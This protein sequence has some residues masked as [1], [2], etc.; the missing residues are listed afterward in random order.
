MILALIATSVL[1]ISF[2]A[3]LLVLFGVALMVAE[4]FLPSFGVLGI[5]GFAA[6]VIGSVLLVDPHNEFGLRLSWTTIAPGVA[7]VALAA[8]TI[9]HL[10]LKA[11]R[12]RVNSG[13]ESLVGSMAVV[14]KDFGDGVG[15]VRISGED[16]AAQLQNPTGDQPRAGQEVTVKHVKGLVL[17]V[18]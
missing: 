5:G 9:G 14:L 15:R 10:I 13:V 3:L 11:K 1:P 12:S 6:F 2:G 4:M 17:I 8:L 18:S 7:A 16:W